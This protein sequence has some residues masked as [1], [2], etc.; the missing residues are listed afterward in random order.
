M[1]ERTCSETQRS[2]RCPTVHQCSNKTTLWLNT[3]QGYSYTLMEPEDKAV[4]G[5]LT[6]LKSWENVRQAGLPICHPA[7]LGLSPPKWWHHKGAP[8]GKQVWQRLVS[9]HQDYEKQMEAEDSSDGDDKA[10]VSKPWSSKGKSK[11]QPSS[12]NNWTRPQMPSSTRSSTKASSK[13]SG[14]PSASTSKASATTAKSLRKRTA[15]Y[16]EID[17]IGEEG[18][19]SVLAAN[20]PSAPVENE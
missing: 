5:W 2:P 12:A 6:V 4:V 16:V 11:A 7:N 8:A 15:D 19:S 1:G 9:K 14:Q 17:L 3:K 10:S 20:T 13:V 18:A